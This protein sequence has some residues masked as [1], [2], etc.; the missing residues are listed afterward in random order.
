M[1]NISVINFKLIKYNETFFFSF[2]DPRLWN[3]MHV[4]HWFFWATQEFSL[5]GL[6]LEPLQFQMKGKDILALGR[7]TFVQRTPPFMG[8]ILWEHLDILQK[9]E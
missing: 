5:E 6:N 9:G 1:K 2:T 7:E 8:D 4:A 3:E